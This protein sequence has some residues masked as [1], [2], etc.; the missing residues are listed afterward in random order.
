[1]IPDKVL[2]VALGALL[3]GAGTASAH[4]AITPPQAAAIAQPA[5]RE[6]CGRT[7][8]SGTSICDE[9][10]ELYYASSYGVHTWRVRFDFR[11]SSE[12]FPNGR[13][14]RAYVF[15][16]HRRI[17]RTRKTCPRAR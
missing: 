4:L 14:C 3:V 2:L 16:L 10:S 6:L 7:T 11:E 1:M 15:V 12:R 17:A 8:I 13:A 9:F 5:A